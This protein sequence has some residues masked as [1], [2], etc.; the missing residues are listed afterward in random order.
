MT[1][2]PAPPDTWG[3][4]WFR[5]VLFST[6][7]LLLAQIWAE[8]QSWIIRSEMQHTPR[9]LAILFGTV[10]FF[11]SFAVIREHRALGWFGLVTAVPCML[12][13]LLPAIAYN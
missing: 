11:S 7:T 9:T 6:V 1:L 3:A 8:T 10:L 5:C 13:V 4:V 2:R 12:M